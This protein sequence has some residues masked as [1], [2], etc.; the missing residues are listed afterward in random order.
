MPN[1]SHDHVHLASPAPLK[2]AEFYES[3]F[4]AKRLA[5]TTLPDG[6]TSITL[7]LNGARIMIVERRAQAPSVPPGTG[8][9]LDHFG[10]KTDDIEATVAELKANGV[11]FRDEIRQPSPGIKIAFFWAPDDVLIELLERSV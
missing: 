10:I 7:D 1:Y 11:K 4:N 3:R 2:T 5:M 9:G 8:I 6:R